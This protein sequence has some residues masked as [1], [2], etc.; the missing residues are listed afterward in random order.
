MRDKSPGRRFS[1]VMLLSGL[2]L[3]AGAPARAGMPRPAA[4][5]AAWQAPPGEPEGGDADPV[6]PDALEPG[7]LPKLKKLTPKQINRIRYLELRGMRTQS[8]TPDRVVVKIPREVME[9]FLVEMEGQPGFRG[10]RDR[11]SF[12]RM[13]APQKLHMIARY[14]GAA[15]ADRVE[16]KT[17]PEV[18]VTFR[19]QVLPIVLR[20]CATTACHASTNEEAAGFRLFKDPKKTPASVY[21]NFVILNDIE[22]GH[23]RMINRGQPENS[24]LLS[25]L[26]PKSQVRPELR[27]PGDVAYKPIFRSRRALKYRQIER[28]IASLKHPAE[29]Y[30]VR[31]VPRP[32]GEPA[33]KG[34]ADKA[35][36]DKGA[37]KKPEASR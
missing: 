8:P 14:R 9:D 30:G 37:G 26:L 33:E 10:E 18:F 21:A 25:Y 27:H 34:A 35:D 7:A 2:L 16:I 1:A 29:D 12:Y 13:T 28:W 36:G 15:Y 23:R 4:A 19:R 32:P 6:E 17:D 11:R 31:L 3:S 22:V 5:A 24:L 20:G